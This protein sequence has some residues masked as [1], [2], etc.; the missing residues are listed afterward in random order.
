MMQLAV[1]QLRLIDRTNR[2][3]IAALCRQFDRAYCGRLVLGGLDNA[4]ELLLS[5]LGE[6]PAAG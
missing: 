1:P 3:W 5:K 6:L 2:A 4:A